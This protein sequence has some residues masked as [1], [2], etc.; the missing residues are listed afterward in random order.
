MDEEQRIQMLSWLDKTIATL[1]QAQTREEIGAAAEG[2]KESWKEVS[3]NMPRIP[4]IDVLVGYLMGGT[5]RMRAPKRYPN[6]ESLEKHFLPRL[7]ELRSMIAERS[8]GE[9]L[10]EVSGTESPRTFLIVMA[11]I[12]IIIVAVVIVVKLY[13]Q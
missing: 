3:N 12:V 8:L 6:R 4:Q 11:L 5:L 7:R 2:I 9:V 1:E 10:P 13:S